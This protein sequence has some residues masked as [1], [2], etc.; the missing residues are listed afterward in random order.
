LL[1]ILSLPAYFVF[2]TIAA[3]KGL[4]ELMV[5]PFYWDKT[6]HG[7]FGGNETSITPEPLADPSRVDLQ[8]R[9]KRHGKMVAER[10]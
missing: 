7:A 4:F 9:L 5:R 8:T 2:G 6:E 10:A 1:W 3:Y